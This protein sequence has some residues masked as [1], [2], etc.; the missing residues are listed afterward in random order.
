MGKVWGEKSEKSEQSRQKCCPR[1]VWRSG[2]AAVAR[3]WRFAI[4]NHI[5]PMT[6]RQIVK[7][8]EAQVSLKCP[9]T[10]HFASFVIS[11]PFVPPGVTATFLIG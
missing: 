1:V 10:V 8:R 4:T 3:L 7:Q 5:W 2:G 9:Q 11:N 6:T